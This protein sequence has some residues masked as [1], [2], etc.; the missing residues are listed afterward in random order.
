[1]TFSAFSCH[2]HN[3]A[4]LGFP[5]LLYTWAWAVLQEPR[6]HPPESCKHRAKRV[7]EPPIQP[8]IYFFSRKGNRAPERLQAR[9]ESHSW[10]AAEPTL[11]L[12]RLYPRLPSLARTFSF[13]SVVI[14]AD[15]NLPAR[16][17]ACHTAHRGVHS[18]PEAEGSLPPARPHLPLQP[19]LHEVYLFF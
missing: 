1:M 17:D 13:S 16:L 11:E 12:W 7:Q 8:L 9:A 6:L 2:F 18:F 4:G 19:A 15:P 5:S 3:S 10:L 14:L